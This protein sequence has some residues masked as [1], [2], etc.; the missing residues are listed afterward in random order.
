MDPNK[1]PEAVEVEELPDAWWYKV[2]AAVVV[3]TVIVVFALW[4]FTKFFS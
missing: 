1:T 4:G 3:T 2:Y